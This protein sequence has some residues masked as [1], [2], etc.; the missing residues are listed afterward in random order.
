MKE[1]HTP[2]PWHVGYG[3][4]RNHIFGPEGSRR[5]LEE[6]GGTTLYPIAEANHGW[7]EREDEANARLIAASP[8]LLEFA[9]EMR[10][11][12]DLKMIGFRDEYPENHCIVDT[13]KRYLAQCDAV[14]SKAEGRTP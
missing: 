14:V 7:D 9:K 10:G 2:G 3:N 4:G 13:A 8:E 5:R 11:Y 1:T 6:P 12:L